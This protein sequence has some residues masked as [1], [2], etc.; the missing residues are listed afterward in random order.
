MI[1][2]HD[3]AF[4]VIKIEIR[5]FNHDFGHCNAGDGFESVACSGEDGGREFGFEVCL[6]IESHRL[7]I[8]D[9]VWTLT[10]Q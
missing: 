2:D 4:K 9:G 3:F 8:R 5:V 10:M 6:T 1:V 7:D